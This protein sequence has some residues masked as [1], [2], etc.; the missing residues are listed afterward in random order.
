MPAPSCW[1]AAQLRS[2]QISSA[3]MEAQPRHDKKPAIEVGVTP[4][5]A[6]AH[7][8]PV[9]AAQH[10]RPRIVWSPRRPLTHYSLPRFHDKGSFLSI[11]LSFILLTSY[12]SFFSCNTRI[13]CTKQVGTLTH[14]HTHNHKQSQAHKRTAQ[15]LNQAVNGAWYSSSR[16]ICNSAAKQQGSS[17]PHPTYASLSTRRSP[18]SGP[19]S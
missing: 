10:N 17:S 3:R 6:Q 19:C 16:Y 14:T 2:A 5:V 18:K 12:S 15:G 7:A 9:A 1:G 8:H 11:S 13:S 4:A